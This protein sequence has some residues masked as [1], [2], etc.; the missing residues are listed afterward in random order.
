M[1]KWLWKIVQEQN[2]IYSTKNTINDDSII[3]YYVDGD[4]KGGGDGLI[5]GVNVEPLS[6]VCETII[7]IV[8]Q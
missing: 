7:K 3:P 8:Y 4:Y 6:F 5:I 1:V 2:Y